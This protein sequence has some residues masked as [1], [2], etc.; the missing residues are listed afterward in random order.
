MQGGGEGSVSELRVLPGGALE[1]L[2]SL[3]LAGAQ[4]GEGIV[5]L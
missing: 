1:G 5:A 4:G 2:G 3:T